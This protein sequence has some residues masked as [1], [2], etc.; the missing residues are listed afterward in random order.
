MFI[1]HSDA[2]K[3]SFV[4]MLLQVLLRYCCPPSPWPAEFVTPQ[5]EPLEEATARPSSS[6]ITAALHMG[7]MQ[8]LEMV[9]LAIPPSGAVTGLLLPSL[10]IHS[11]SNLQ[12]AFKAAKELFV[13]SCS[14]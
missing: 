9:L 10:G 2:C 3:Q 13:L 6:L 1:L 12:H 14:R 4:C 5:G 7:N 8:L 11:F